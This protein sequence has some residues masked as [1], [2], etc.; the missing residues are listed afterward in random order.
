[1]PS[2]TIEL[3]NVTNQEVTISYK[4]YRDGSKTKQLTLKNE[5]FTRRFSLHI[6]PKRF[7]RIRHYGDF[8]QQLE[9]RKLQQLQKEL[10]VLRSSVEP[11]TN[12]ENVIVVKLEILLRCTFLGSEVHQKLILLKTHFLL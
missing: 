5:E 9:T 3:K 2:V 1:M 12:I 6:L 10:N 8:K 11:K 7:V 4:D